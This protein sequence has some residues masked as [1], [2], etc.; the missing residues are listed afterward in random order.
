VATETTYPFTVSSAFPNGLNSDRFALEI[1]QTTAITIALDR[2]DTANGVCNVVFRDVL[3]ASD[4]T[5]LNALPAAHSGEPLPEPAKDALGNPIVRIYGDTAVGLPAVMVLDIPDTAVVKLKSWQVN[6]PAQ[7]TLIKDIFIGDDFIGPLGKCYLAGGEYRVRATNGHGAV[8]GSALH[9]ALVDRDD[10]LGYFGFYGMNRTKI[11][12][13]TNITGTI[14]I[15]DT[16][17][18]GTSGT[19]ADVLSVGADTCDVTY[20]NGPFTNGEALTF[21]GG[22]TA[23]LGTWVEG[24]VIEIVRNVKDEWIE[25]YDHRE[26]SPGGSREIPTGLYLR[27][28]AYNAHATDALRVKVSFTFGAA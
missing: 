11:S 14:N 10:L 5:A 16:V 24:D 28:I 22:A 15:G 27:I 1:R 6:V 25:D 18:G 3:P 26:Y 4:E 20:H 8:E 21:S 19:I 2:L 9:L 23:T 7:T 12:G 17:T 13:L